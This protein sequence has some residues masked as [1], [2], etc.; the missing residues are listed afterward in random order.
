MYVGGFRADLL[1]ASQGI[2][3]LN[4]S[5]DPGLTSAHLGTEVIMYACGCP[6]IARGCRAPKGETGRT[7]NPGKSQPEKLSDCLL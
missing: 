4:P 6:A 3:A 1:A 2:G 5:P 7:Q